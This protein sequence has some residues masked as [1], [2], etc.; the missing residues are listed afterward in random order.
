MSVG[1]GIIW[2]KT[3]T[4]ALRGGISLRRGHLYMYEPDL[5]DSSKDDLY[6]LGDAFKEAGWLNGAGLISD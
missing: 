6:V 1:F 4:R 3:G 2:W 5:D